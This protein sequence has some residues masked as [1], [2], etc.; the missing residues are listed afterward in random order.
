MKQFS[1]TVR[2]L[3]H[4]SQFAQGLIKGQGNGQIVLDNV[5]LSEKIENGDLVV[6]GGT[7]DIEGIGLPPD[8]VIGKIY[9]L[10][11]NPSALFQKAE[12]KSFI[13]S[14]QLSTLFIITQ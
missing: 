2:I 8:L 13:D 12:V 14:V 11:K 10:Q 7:K 3:K 6:T 9:A 1:T 5:L 4:D